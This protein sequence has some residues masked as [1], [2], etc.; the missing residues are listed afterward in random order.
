MPKT[1]FEKIWETH[2]VRGPEQEG[3]P[4]LLYID[5]HLVHEVTSAQ[6][7]EG[8]R[9]AG[10]KVRRPTGPWRPP[11]TTCPPTRAS[12]PASTRSATSSP[13]SRSRRSSATAPSSASRYTGCAAAARASCT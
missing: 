11:T 7:F 6:A 10:R 5:L 3:G 9:L 2:E 12:A 1:M 8:L 13:A 4:S